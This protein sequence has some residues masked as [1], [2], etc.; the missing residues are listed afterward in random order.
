MNI[1]YSLQCTPYGSWILP[2]WFL[3]H[4]YAIKMDLY[5]KS[6]VFLESIPFKACFGAKETWKIENHNHTN[7]KCQDICVW[8]G[9][10]LVP[11]YFLSQ[12]N[13]L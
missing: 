8:I 2:F 5:Y 3:S 13:A 4:L 6:W 7:D 1:E 12:L 10:N 9:Q 11:F